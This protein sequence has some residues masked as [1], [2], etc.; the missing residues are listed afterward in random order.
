MLSWYWLVIFIVLYKLASNI[1]KLIRC[2]KLANEYN[3]FLR[4]SDSNNVYH[5]TQE[6]KSLILGAG[7]EDMVVPV[8]QPAGFGMVHSMKPSVLGQYPSN[9]VRF[10][11]S[12]IRMFEQAIGVYKHRIY[13]T[14]NP[15]YWID[16]II[17]LPRNFLN[18]LG[19]TVTSVGSKLICSI[20]QIIYWAL[21]I[22]YIYYHAEMKSLLLSIIERM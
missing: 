3:Q 22:A 11:Y 17:W 14:I 9:D 8:M 19:I 21:S 15:L 20:F 7:V 10:A 6:V 13:E 18:Y 4:G 1:F 12:T 16:L 5:S 2:I